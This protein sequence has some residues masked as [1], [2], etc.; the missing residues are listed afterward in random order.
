MRILLVEDDLDTAHIFQSFL[1]H[2]GH[3]SFFCAY[4]ERA[5]YYTKLYKPDVILMDISLPGQMSG[6][7]AAEAIMGALDIPVIFLTVHTEMFEEAVAIE[8]CGFLLKTCTPRELQIALELAVKAQEGQAARKQYITYLEQVM[9]QHAD[10]L[11]HVAED[12]DESR[13]LMQDISLE[14]FGYDDD[15]GTLDQMVEEYEEFLLVKYLKHYHDNMT[16]TAQALGIN[17]ATLYR[18]CKKHGINIEKKK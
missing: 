11:A 12:Y 14:L 17:L 8:G 2:L 15:H 4:G 3:Q 13:K 1:T 5:L 7:Q 18:K 16:A 10:L 6:I 9:Q